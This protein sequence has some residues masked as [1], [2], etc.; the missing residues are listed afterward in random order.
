[1]L[2]DTGARF[3]IAAGGVPALCIAA[4]PDGGSVRARVVDAVSGAV[5]EQEIT[6]DLPASA[7]VLSPRLL[8][9]NGATAAAVACDGAGVDLE[10]D[11]RMLV[12][13]SLNLRR[14]EGAQVARRDGRR[15]S[16]PVAGS[17]AGS[18]LM[19]SKFNDFQNKFLRK[20]GPA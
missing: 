9:A 16:S 5:L 13:T 1:M 17:T 2:G 8:M 11:G 6:A 19:D 14:S 7:Q 10:T 15:R 20:S 3:S 4:P 12:R 18:M